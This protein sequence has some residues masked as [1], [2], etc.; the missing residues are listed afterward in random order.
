MRGLS[1]Q[2]ILF[3]GAIGLYVACITTLVASY[4]AVSSMDIDVSMYLQAPS[5]LHAELPTAARGIVMNA[6][7]G[8]L[9]V[10]AD[11]SFK[12]G[13]E[14]IGKAETQPHGHLHVQLQPSHAA[15]GNQNLN[16]TVDHPLVEE[17]EVDVPVEVVAEQDSFQWPEATSRQ[18][19]EKRSR[20]E[21]WEGELKVRV[22]PGDG[23]LPRGLPSTIYLLLIDAETGA[24]VQGTIALDKLEGM[25]DSELPKTFQT[26]E[27]G[28]AKVTLTAVT[29][30]RWT[31]TATASGTADE[32][33]DKAG[34]KKE[35]G[36]KEE[37]E[38]RSGTGTVRIYTVASQFSFS[39]SRLIAVPG[40]PVEGLVHTLHRSGGILVD[41]YDGT[42]WAHA[43]AFGISAK[44]AGVRS[45]VPTDVK[46]P[47]VRMQVYQDLFGAASAWDSR[48]LIV[49]DSAGPDACEPALRKLLN[50]HVVH[51]PDLADWASHALKSPALDATFRTGTC[52]AW[53]E[54]ALLG[55]PHRFDP[56]PL[57]VNTQKEDREEL[58]GWRKGVQAKLIIATS[59]VLFVGF[60]FVLLLVLRGMKRAQMHAQVIREVE[61]ETASEAELE[62]PKP[63]DVD[64]WLV[65]LQTVIIIATIFTFGMSLLMLLSWM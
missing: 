6:P 26:D 52:S 9:F 28:L 41:L 37:G 42:R 48:W 14:T 1:L 39:P 38:G 24:P 30:Q 11:T 65:V 29:S 3:R 8:N 27:L 32:G 34:D 4:I 60:A 51:N 61:L 53:L 7:T 12:I 35:Q 59:G 47:L 46:S 31:L 56:A 2:T 57:L 21:E 18:T 58:E 43:D 33:D 10:G 40:Q 5:T 36:D 64:K 45:I 13:E 20:E 44:G 49:S 15:V 63:F 17:F 50:L 25:V 54:A 62:T 23:E 19:D 22:L 55:V 16:L